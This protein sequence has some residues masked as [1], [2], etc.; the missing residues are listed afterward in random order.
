M[1]DRHE[2]VLMSDRLLAWRPFIAPFKPEITPASSAVA[3]EFA[4]QPSLSALL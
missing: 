1:R 4:C 2:I 3:S